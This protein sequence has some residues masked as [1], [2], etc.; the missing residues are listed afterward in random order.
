MTGTDFANWWD[1]TVVKNQG[2]VVTWIKE[3]PGLASIVMT[4]L[5]PMAFTGADALVDVARIGE[6]FGE[7]ASDEA[8]ALDVAKGL[9]TDAARALSVIPFFRAPGMVVKFGLQRVAVRA[10]LFTAARGGLCTEIA[11]T[12]GIRRAGRAIFM[13]LDDILLK[14]RGKPL[15]ELSQA[16]KAGGI[17]F[18]TLTSALKDL[19]IPHKL[20]APLSSFEEI[21]NALKGND[22]ILFRVRWLA[23][24]KNGTEQEATHTLHAFKDFAGKFRISDRTGHIVSSLEEL[25]KLVPGYG[26]IENAVL[27]PNNRILL[28]QGLQVLELADK[29]GFA[30]FM[31]PL[32]AQV[33]V[34]ADQATPEMVTQ[35]VEATIMRDVQGKIPATIPPPQAKAPSAKQLK[36]KIPPVE[37]LTGVKFRL[38]HLGYSAGPPV[39]LYN[40]R[41]K[42]AIRQFQ[43]D[44]GL[45]ADG[46]PGPK[47]QAKLRDV[48]KY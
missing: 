42:R 35:S 4:P 27:A 10:S 47:T 13:K 15:A 38:N 7:A 44:Y 39:H 11:A 40:D 45:L 48:C 25:G 29:A 32:R 1:Q 28:I 21:S 23:K 36:P 34:N 24:L 18:A 3:N 8:T 12:Q 37:W 5:I 6:G 22:V 14:T 31:L 9:G 41:C 26:G 46:V 20:L 30:V 17:N 43:S 2:S 19:R 33:V 16:E